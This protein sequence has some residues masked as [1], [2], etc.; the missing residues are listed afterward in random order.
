MFLLS[1]PLA[2]FFITVP[3]GIISPNRIKI[4]LSFSTSPRYL[5]SSN[6]LC[7]FCCVLHA[8]CPS[9]ICRCYQNWL[10]LK[11]AKYLSRKALHVIGNRF[12]SRPMQALLAVISECLVSPSQRKWNDSASCLTWIHHKF[13]SSSVTLT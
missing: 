6:S 2:N 8:D 11:R 10:K 4:C 13:F 1:L 5:C 3:L 12:E 7:E 9:I